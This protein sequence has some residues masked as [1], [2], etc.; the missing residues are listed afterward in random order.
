MLNEPPLKIQYKNWRGVIAEREILPRRCYFGSNE[1]HTE[2]QWLM[3]AWDVQKDAM[4]TFA[5]S[6]ITIL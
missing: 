3:T 6:D 4:R 1:W 5:M 2:N